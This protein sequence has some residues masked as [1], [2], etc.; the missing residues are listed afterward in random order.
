MFKGQEIVKVGAYFRIAFPN[1]YKKK[2]GE[3]IILT[4][5]LDKSLLA[6]SE[7]DWEALRKREV[8]RVSFLDSNAR[9]LRRLFLAGVSYLEFDDQNRFI[10]PEYLRKYSQININEKVVFAWQ[11]EYL[12][13]WKQE[14]WNKRLEKI[15][16]NSSDIANRLIKGPNADE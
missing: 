13:V 2:L 8:E 16:E 4:Y 10:L 6:A 7:S 11:G 5:N 1:E 15:L 12:E 14:F 9:D 3:K